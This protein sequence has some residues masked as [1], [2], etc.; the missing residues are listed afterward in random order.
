MTKHKDAVPEFDVSW[1]LA[2]RKDKHRRA[3]NSFLLSPRSCFSDGEMRILLGLRL[4]L[5]RTPYVAFV[6]SDGTVNPRCKCGSMGTVTHFLNVPKDA[7]DHSAALRAI[8]QCRHAE[9]TAALVNWI[10]KLTT[11]WKL[12]SGDLVV[13]DPCFSHVHAAITA[14]RARRTLGLSGNGPQHYKPDVVI[15]K[16]P[17]SRRTYLILDVCFRS[18]AKLHAEDFVTANWVQPRGQSNQDIFSSNWFDVTGAM[19]LTGL[20]RLRPELR[21]RAVSVGIFKQSS[22]VKRYSPYRS[23]LSNTDRGCSVSIKTI[24]IGVAGL[25]PDFTRVSLEDIGN[26]AAVMSLLKEAR[27]ISWRFAISAFKAWRAED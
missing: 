2:G 12:V 26:K 10:S 22:Y 8:P 14:A 23:V 11:G 17:P 13:G 24:A 1:G 3:N 4:R 20:N 9:F 19:T 5:W 21:D 15:A 16:G 27:F 7:L 6:R 18:D 25:I